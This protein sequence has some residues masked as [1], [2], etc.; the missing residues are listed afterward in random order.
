MLF[1]IYRKT[2]EADNDAFWWGG[3][4]HYRS[5]DDG[6]MYLY[7]FIVFIS[8]LAAWWCDK[9]RF[10]T[11]ASRCGS[12]YKISR[13]FLITHMILLL[14]MG[15]R[16]SWVGIDTIVYSQTFENATSL[17]AVFNDDSTTEP[18][19]KI[20]MFIL[21]TIFFSRHVAIFIF[22]ALIM[23][24]V[25]K[26][27][28]KYY[29]SLCLA[30]AIPAFVCIYYFHSFNLIRITLAASFLLWSTPLLVNEKYKQYSIRI[31]VTTFMHYSS[32]VLFLPLGLLIVYKKNRTL[33]YFSAL[34]VILLI[35]AGTRMLGDYIVLLNRY[36]DYILGNKSSGQIGLA[37]FIDYLPCLFTSC[38][39]LRKKIHSHWGDMMVCFTMA[40]FIIRLLA[41][42][43]TATG[44]L[45]IHFMPLTLIF[46][47]YWLN[48]IR[49]KNK[50][51]Y[52]IA[53]QLC[54]MWLLLRLHI[55]FIGYLS[56]DGIMPYN[57]FWSE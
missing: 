42:F 43:I 47:P 30:V 10:V 37:L 27:L 21:R 6:T 51:L 24:F 46:L 17:S 4:T 32:I 8:F 25:F 34:G 9:R 22:S 44:R 41:Y 48:Y 19:Y 5:W 35:V 15:L 33:A 2:F 56:T 49:Q 52:N 11:N 53:I 54:V 20:F 16:G 31:L 45:H 36:E 39:I 55:Y 26:T 23:Y 40:A 7:L 50:S 14:F 3:E 29:N 18:L 57:F 13:C 12:K 28:K 1:D 38:Y